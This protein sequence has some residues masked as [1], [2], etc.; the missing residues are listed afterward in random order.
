MILKKNNLEIYKGSNN[1]PL[2]NK[3]EERFYKE[4]FDKDGKLINDCGYYPVK[5]WF[6]LSFNEI[7]SLTFK[8]IL[9]I[10]QRYLNI[11]QNNEKYEN[12]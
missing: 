1:E 9:K 11:E 3:P 12:N 8:D 7:D 10:E 5:H 4:Q 2:E 6:T